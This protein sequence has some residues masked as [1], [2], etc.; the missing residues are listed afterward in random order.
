VRFDGTVP[1][2]GNEK[3]WLADHVPPAFID[4]ENA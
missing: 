2:A 4:F 1:H 3:A